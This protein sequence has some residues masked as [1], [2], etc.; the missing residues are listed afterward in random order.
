[1]N[2]WDE[3]KRQ[4]AAKRANDLAQRAAGERRRPEVR[5]D[6]ELLLDFDNALH[7]Y[8]ASMPCT[9]FTR[10]PGLGG[11]RLPRVRA[12]YTDKGWSVFLIGEDGS[13]W[14]WKDEKLRRL[15]NLS[16]R[17]MRSLMRRMAAELANPSCGF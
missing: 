3:A 7:Q 16:E 5:E 15:E 17:E 2:A 8:V 10:W 11:R 12:M 9:A 4:V 13:L 6:G 1:M 14:G